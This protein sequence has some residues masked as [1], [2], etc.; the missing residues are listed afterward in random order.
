L[1][2]PFLLERFEAIDGRENPLLSN[3]LNN[4]ALHCAISHLFLLEK[5]NEMNEPFFV[6][7]EDDL[8]ITN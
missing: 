8:E 6:I 7:G 4:G 3:K 5:L 2:L 1:R